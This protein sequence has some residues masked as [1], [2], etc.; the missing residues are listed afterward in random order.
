MLFTYSHF[1]DKEAET[2][3][4]EKVFDKILLPCD[5]LGQSKVSGSD[6]WAKR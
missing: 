1:V 3:N 4:A 5:I 6:M 2:Q